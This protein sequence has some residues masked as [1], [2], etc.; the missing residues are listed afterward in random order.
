MLRPLYLLPDPA[1]EAAKLGYN[2][3]DIAMLR[4]FS[5]RGYVII[6]LDLEESIPARVISEVK[7]QYGKGLLNGPGRVQDAK[8]QAVRDLAGNKKVLQVLEILHGRKAFPFQTLN[9]NV[10][11]EQMTHSDVIHFDS[12]PPGFMAGVWVALEDIHA[13]NGPLHYYPGSH[14]LPHLTLADFGARS[15]RSNYAKVYEPGIQRLVEDRSLKKEEGYLRRGQA[16]IW[17]ANLLHGGSPILQEG[18]TR[19]S[20]VTHYYFEGC[21]YFKPLRSDPVLGRVV[22]KRPKDV[23]T[24]KAVT[25]V[26]AGRRVRRNVIVN[27]LSLLR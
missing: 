8:S 19:H 7:P 23:R 24:G 27:L 22:I 12:S 6:D 1:A 10:G 5:E 16:L 14:K 3:S 18:S 26:Y 11:T 25:P 13:K 15:G 4:E 2:Q 20:Q 21:T 9:F 17:S